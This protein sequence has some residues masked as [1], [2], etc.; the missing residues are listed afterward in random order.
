MRSVKFRMMLVAVATLYGC[1]NQPEPSVDTAKAPAATDT[2]AVSPHDFWKDVGLRFDP[3]SIAIGQQ[4]GSLTVARLAISKA[5]DS[6]RVGS[7]W[8]RGNIELSGRAMRHPDSEVDQLCFEAD[9]TS[10][11]RM[12][13]W[14]DDARRPW[15]CFRDS[16][17]AQVRLGQLGPDSLVRI[18]VDSFVIHRG[19]SDEV[20]TARLLRRSD[21]S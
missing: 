19:M 2:L 4:F 5:Y 10:A 11:A 7:A 21:A 13:R 8:F 15:F 12:P 1:A 16:K 3:D 20:N 6:T 14:M 17:R 18:V 9:S